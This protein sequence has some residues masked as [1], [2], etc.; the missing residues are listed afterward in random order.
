MRAEVRRASVR[1]VW[2]EEPVA[3]QNAGAWIASDVAAGGHRRTRLHASCAGDFRERSHHRDGVTV[4]EQ[5]ATASKALES[6]D[7][8]R[9]IGSGSLAQSS[10]LHR[11]I[12]HMDVTPVP[13]V[14]RSVWQAY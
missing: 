7:K 8:S 1:V 3:G 4:A 6:A 11:Q 13:S 2:I 9:S 5:D 12:S 10:D 14:L